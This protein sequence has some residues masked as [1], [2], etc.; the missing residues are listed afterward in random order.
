M[1][2]AIEAAVDEYGMFDVMYNDAGIPVASD[3]SA[4]MSGVVMPTCDG[5]TLSRVALMF[6]AAS[7]RFA[8]EAQHALA[9]DVVLDLVGASVDR[10]GARVEEGV[11]VPGRLAVP[12]EDERFGA[13]HVEHQLAERSVPA[14]PVDLQDGSDRTGVATVSSAASSR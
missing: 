7:A 11:L 4:Y 14:R 6:S 3:E 8:G 9:D 10:L 1:K 12:L 13:E 5:G 2:A